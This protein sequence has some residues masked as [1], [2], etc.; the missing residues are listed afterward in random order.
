MCVAVDLVILL[1]VM[2]GCADV[3]LSC[4][5]EQDQKARNICQTANAAISVV[6]TLD[7]SFRSRLLLAWNTTGGKVFDPLAHFSHNMEVRV[8]E[9]TQHFHY[10]DYRIL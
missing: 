5:Q 2:F 4:G 1:L 10:E 7:S 9:L 8:T 6:A 3:Q